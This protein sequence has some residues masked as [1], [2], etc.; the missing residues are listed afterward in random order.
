MVRTTLTRT[1]GAISTSIS[2]AS[3]ITF[4]TRPTRPPFGD[5]RVVAPDVL[6]QGLVILDPPLLRP[7][8]QE[9]HD[10]EDEDEGNHLQGDLGSAG[11]SA[12]PLREGGGD[13]ARLLM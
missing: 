7:Q 12:G 5:D 1:F 13:Q 3:S 10:H 8:D 11:S 9:I 6:D 2:E 4:T